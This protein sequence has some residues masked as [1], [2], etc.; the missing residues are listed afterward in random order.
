MR[1]PSSAAVSDLHRFSRPGAF[2]GNGTA[3]PGPSPSYYSAAVTILFRKVFESPLGD[4]TLIASSIGLRAVLWPDDA[5]DRV[6]LGVPVDQI[7]A[8]DDAPVLNEAAE[9]LAEYFGSARTSFDLPLDL[10]HGTGFQRLAWTALADI[11]YGATRTYAE[12]AKAID[13]PKAVRAVGAANGRNPISIVLPCHR[14]IGSDGSLTGFAA[15]VEA[16][17][18]LLEL[19][20][21]STDAPTLPG[22]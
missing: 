16:K 2:V 6:R 19:E 17:R 11:P 3:P 21:W 5:E 4:L 8:V 18:F 12:Q 14:V 13:R 1:P 9:Q 10:E 20:G 7:E 22:L 15:G